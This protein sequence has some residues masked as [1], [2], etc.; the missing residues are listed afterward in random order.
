MPVADVREIVGPDMLVGLSTHTP[1]QIDAAD[2][3][4][5]DY[6]GVGPGARDADQARAPGGRRSSWSR[7]AAAHARVPF[8]AIGGIDAGQR[9]RGARRR[10]RRASCVLRAIADA[11]DPERAARAL[12][13]AARAQRPR[14]SAGASADAQRRRGERERASAQRGPALAPL[15]AR[16]SAPRRCVVAIAVCAAARG[17]RDR[18]ARSACTTSAATAARCPGA[19]FLAGVLLG[20]ARAGMYRRRYWAVLGFEALLAFQIIVTSLALVVA[21]DAARRGALRC[22]AIGLGGGCSGSWCA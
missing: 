1:A 14:V 21:V 18:R 17:R 4:L 20:A 2:P 6:I 5:V 10:A 3:A 16:T 13:D 19:L 12:R 8:F 9:R 15:G 7:Y 22:S 11:A